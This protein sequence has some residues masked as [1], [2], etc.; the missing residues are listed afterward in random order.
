MLSVKQGSELHYSVNGINLE[1]G[2][3]L[4]VRVKQ[5]AILNPWKVLVLLW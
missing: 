5:T 2:D 4:Q 3:R 1:T